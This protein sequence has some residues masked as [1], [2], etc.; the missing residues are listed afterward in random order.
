MLLGEVSLGAFA[1][2]AGLSVLM[3][4]LSYSACNRL[5]KKYTSGG[6]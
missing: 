1:A 3:M 2:V 4:V 6:G 5:V